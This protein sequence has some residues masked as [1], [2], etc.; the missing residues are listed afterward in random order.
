MSWFSVKMSKQIISSFHSLVIIS[1]IICPIMYKMFRGKM[2]NQVKLHIN[3]NLY[4][5]KIVT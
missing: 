5:T 3:Y 2:S 4:G 1:K